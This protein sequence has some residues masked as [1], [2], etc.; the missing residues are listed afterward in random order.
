MQEEMKAPLIA[1]EKRSG[2]RELAEQFLVYFVLTCVWWGLYW[3]MIAF[4]NKAYKDEGG[5]NLMGGTLGEYPLVSEIFG[6]TWTI[7]VI[8]FWVGHCPMMFR[9]RQHLDRELHTKI[10][11]AF[12]AWQLAETI[13]LIFSSAYKTGLVGADG[14]APLPFL[15]WLMYVLCCVAQV[16]T[17]CA[18]AFY[19]V[20]VPTIEE[21]GFTTT[22]RA[23]GVIG[24]LLFLV[25]MTYD[26]ITQIFTEGEPLQTS[27]NLLR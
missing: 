10:L 13:A 4:I 24:T 9:V 25:C 16:V 14:H 22:W 11:V 19:S 17:S 5:S 15:F 6:Y 1:G 27:E 7:G 18:W 21:A 3:D 8:G 12:A 2:H 23:L 20:K 26:A